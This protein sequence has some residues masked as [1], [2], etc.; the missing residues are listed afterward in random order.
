MNRGKCHLRPS[1]KWHFQ[2]GPGLENGGYLVADH[3]S[4]LSEAGRAAN[5][6]AQEFI[7]SALF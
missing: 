2:G 4:M 6:H 5:E 1:E 7:I 3:I